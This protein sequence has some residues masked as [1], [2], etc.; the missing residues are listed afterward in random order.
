MSALI[1]TVREG[2]GAYIRDKTTYAGT[3]TGGLMR[4]EGRNR[5]ILRYI[6]LHYTHIILYI[7]LF[8]VPLLMRRSDV[9]VDVSLVKDIEIVITFNVSI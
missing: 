9:S 3:C 1:F 5:G 8:I 7:N 4:K 6:Q 2:G